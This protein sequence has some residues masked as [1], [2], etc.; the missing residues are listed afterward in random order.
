MKSDF[1]VGKGQIITKRFFLAEDSPKKANENTSHT[2]KNE[3][4]HSFFGRI[5]GLTIFFEISSPLG[6]SKMTKN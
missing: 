3:F 6:W 5:L 1:K 2:S 4:L